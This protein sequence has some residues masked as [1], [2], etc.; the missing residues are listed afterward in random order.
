MFLL[1]S[2]L[3]ALLQQAPL[4]GSI[5]GIVTRAGTK[6]PL[7]GVR[8]KTV[9]GAPFIAETITDG[10]GYY[11]LRDI[12]P[13]GVELEASL[14]GY[15]LGNSP[16][17]S[18]RFPVTVTAGQKQQLPPLTG[19][20][21]ATIRGRV[22]D[23]E[24]KGIPGLP[25]AFGR[26]FNDAQGRRQ[27]AGIAQMMGV[28]R[29]GDQGEYLREMLTPGNYYV[30]TS[31]DRP[32]GSSLRVYHPSAAD[33][34]AAAVVVLGEGSEVTAD[35]QVTAGLDDNMHKI[36][37]RVLP[38][39]GKSATPSAGIILTATD[40]KLSSMDADAI[41]ETDDTGKFD[42]RGI[43]Q[44]SYDLFASA[45]I[46][47][48]EYMAKV[49]VDVG[50]RDIEDLEITLLPALEI[51][52]RLVTDADTK[53]L[54]LARPGAGSVRIGLSRKDRLF[55]GLLKPVIDE[56]GTTF[57]FSDVPQGDYTVT[58]TFLAAAGAAPSPDL[59]VA[60]VRASGRSVFDNGLQVGIDPL[61]N[62]EVEIGGNGGTLAGT[63]PGVA[64]GRPAI[65]FLRPE[66]NRRNN[67]ALSRT[68]I[69][70]SPNGE[71]QFRGLPPGNYTLF[72]VP[73]VA[74]L[75]YVNP[76]LVT[77]FEQRGIVAVIRK[78]IPVSGLQVPLLTP[79]R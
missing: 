57:T 79:G 36:S 22:V 72:A 73:Y 69:N 55:D 26:A 1:I 76:D 56:T 59:F 45:N 62:V 12:P 40:P 2:L 24:G 71:F 70:R 64:P 16:N 18:Y 37:G 27:L 19:V 48:K 25:L 78:G 51:K 50:S 65:L 23:G 33:V 7:A 3:A 68:V 44:G 61:D 8:V 15:I 42:L 53:D 38:L 21:A 20:P 6:F 14:D 28:V 13:G 74:E 11:I 60:D 52:G 17:P 46:E 49:P 54:L 4:S 75:A 58:V 66:F 43:R 41:A 9:Q 34:S 63:I 47:G 31:V 32:G 30:W 5:E 29:T 10:T 35:I 39:P 67:P 77:Q